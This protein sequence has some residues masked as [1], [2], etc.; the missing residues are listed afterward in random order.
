MHLNVLEYNI[1]FKILLK[2]FMLFIFIIYKMKYFWRRLTS[3]SH[4]CFLHMMSFCWVQCAITSRLHLGH[5]RMSVKKQLPHPLWVRGKLMPQVEIYTFLRV[6]LTNEA[7]RIDRSDQ[8]RWI[9]GVC[10]DANASCCSE[11]WGEGENARLSI[12]RLGM[13]ETAHTNDQNEFP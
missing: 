12:D 1:F 13:N 10:S 6:L 11:D 9:S 5:L 4:L 8:N 7:R 2:T 3:G